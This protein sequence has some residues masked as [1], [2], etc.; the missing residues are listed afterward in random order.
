MSPTFPEINT[1]LID[2]SPDSIIKNQDD[3]IDL[4]VKYFEVHCAFR[5]IQY[6]PV[7]YTGRLP[8]EIE[9]RLIKMG[10]II[11]YNLAPEYTLI[12]RPHN[13]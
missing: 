9:S 7:Q 8:H 4:T 12:Y 6:N 2:C 11:R 5:L 1:V 13:K 3:V 10:Y